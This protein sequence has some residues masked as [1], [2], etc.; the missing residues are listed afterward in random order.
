M[1]KVF[2]LILPVMLVSGSSD[3]KIQWRHFTPGLKHAKRVFTCP[4]FQVGQEENCLFFLC[5]HSVFEDTFKNKTKT[6][7]SF[8]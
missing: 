2:W 8:S 4:V 6:Q 5:L 3:G 7:S 1:H